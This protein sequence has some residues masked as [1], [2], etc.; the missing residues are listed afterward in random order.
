MVAVAAAVVVCVLHV[1]TGACSGQKR[2]QIL[3]GTGGLDGC[4]LLAVGAGNLTWVLWKN[5]K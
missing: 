2:Y 1:C 3:P 4:E 5:S